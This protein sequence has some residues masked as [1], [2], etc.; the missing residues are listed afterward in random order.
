MTFVE[1]GILDLDKP[2]YE[3]LP[4]PDIKNDERYKKITSRIVLSHRS[5][6]PNWRDS[7]PEKKLFIQCYRVEY[8]V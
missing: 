6:F 4:N 1:D 7:Y 8:L 2:L 3:Y 5:G